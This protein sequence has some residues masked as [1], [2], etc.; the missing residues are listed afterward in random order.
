MNEQKLVGWVRCYYFNYLWI[1]TDWKHFALLFF[2]N[3]FMTYFSSVGYELKT[4]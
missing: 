3:Y 2:L 4:F 1:G